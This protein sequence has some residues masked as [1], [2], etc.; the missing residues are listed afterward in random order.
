MDAEKDRFGDK[1][2]DLEHA[3]ENQFFAER[4]RELLAK[5]RQEPERAGG[6]TCPTCG[7][8]LEA[9]EEPPLRLYRCTA[10]HGLWL[11]GED[12]ET[13]SDPANLALLGRLLARIRTR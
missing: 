4:D 11:N 6:I 5:L 13:S 3:R 1:L 7:L 10:R 12:L 8:A 9:L 2:R